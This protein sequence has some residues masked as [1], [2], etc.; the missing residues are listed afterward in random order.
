MKFRREYRTLLS[1]RGYNVKIIR[2]QN[3]NIFTWKRREYYS[4][5][6]VRIRFV[7]NGRFDVRRLRRSFI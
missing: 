4:D 7:K 5:D 6:N 1:V 2:L 3:V